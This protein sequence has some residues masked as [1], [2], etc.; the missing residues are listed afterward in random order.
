MTADTLANH[1]E[2]TL[3]HTMGHRRTISFNEE[4]GHVVLEFEAKTSQ[5]HS[6]N[7]VQGGFVTGWIDSA[8]AHAIIAKTGGQLT[9]LS[10]DIKIAFY[11]AAHPGIVRAEAWIERL[12]KRTAFVEGQLLDADGNIIAKGMST[13][14]LVPMQ[15]QKP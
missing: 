2:G 13:V 5:C 11:A 15:G 7:I 12:G 10:L 1:P 6:G 9:P 3:L 14:R 8:M 4:T